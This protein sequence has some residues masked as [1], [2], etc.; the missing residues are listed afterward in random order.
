LS[1]TIQQHFTLDNLNMLRRVLD[2]AGLHDGP[3]AA[4]LARLSASRFLIE[5]FQ[6]GISTETDLKSELLNHL[7]QDMSERAR[8]AE[9]A[10]AQ[11]W[12]NEGDALASEVKLSRHS[13]Q[14]DSNQATI[15]RRIILGFPVFGLSRSSIRADDDIPQMLTTAA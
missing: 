6:H 14:L 4:R 13:V 2:N 11:T 15:A 3:D 10:D 1:S 7:H 9:F 5:C 12:E 8:A